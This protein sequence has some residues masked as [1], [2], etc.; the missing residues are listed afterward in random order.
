[1]AFLGKFAPYLHNSDRMNPADWSIIEP[2]IVGAFNLDAQRGYYDSFDCKYLVKNCYAIPSMKYD[3]SKSIANV[4][5][6][7]EY[8]DIDHILRY[9]SINFLDVRNATDS[10]SSIALRAHIICSR[11]LLLQLM[12][13]AYDQQTPW[14]ILACRFRGSIYLCG[15]QTE[16]KREEIANRST[17]EWNKISYDYKFK[18]LIF[19]SKAL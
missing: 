12:N 16:Q 15:K 5:R 3:L 11:E 18:R 9:I 4:V 17:T 13:S 14:T 8:E 1:M 7:K 6:R 2:R 10:Y 19:A